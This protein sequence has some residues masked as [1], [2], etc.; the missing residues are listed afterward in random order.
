[1]N[2]DFAMA[3]LPAAAGLT[4]IF[5]FGPGVLADRFAISDL[6][7]PDS[8]LHAKLAHHAIHNDLKVQFAHAGNQSLS[9]VGI[10][11]YPKSGIFLRKLLE[12]VAELILIRFGLRLDGHRDD[13]SRKFDRFQNDR[14]LLIAKRVARRYA[15]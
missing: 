4:N 1:M 2:L 12:R 11:V 5:A 3:V 10:G 14:L 6:R 15:L 7:T 9:G 13:R 8:R